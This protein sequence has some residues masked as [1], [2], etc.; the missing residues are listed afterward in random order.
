MST[1]H[2]RTA[3]KQDAATVISLINALSL[4]EKRKEL[5]AGVRARLLRDGFEEPRRFTT[6]L[7]ELEN[8]EIGYALFFESYSSFLAKPILYLEDL[9]VLPEARSHGVGLAL[10]KACAAEAI[11]R[12]CCL[13]EWTALDWNQLA[14]DFYQKIGAEQINDRLL[15]RMNRDELATFVAK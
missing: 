13:M 1:V 4:Y 10:L 2:I 12:G 5:D 6:L 7:A 8:K 14:I 3:T 11:A 9:F 15:Y